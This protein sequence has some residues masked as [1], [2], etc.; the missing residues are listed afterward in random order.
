MIGVITFEAVDRADEIGKRS[1]VVGFF[2]QGTGHHWGEAEMFGL[3]I[4]PGFA[5]EGGQRVIHLQE[6][7]GFAQQ[8]VDPHRDQDAL[9]DH[10]V[11]E[12]RLGV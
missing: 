4:C 2:E 9:L 11:P 12:L 1:D 5:N 7:L 3:F 10:P 8:T 6:R